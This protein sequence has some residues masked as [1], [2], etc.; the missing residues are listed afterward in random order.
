MFRCLCSF[1]LP[2]DQNPFLMIG[3]W[4]FILKFDSFFSWCVIDADFR[5]FLNLTF[6]IAL[7]NLCVIIFRFRG[8]R[9]FV[10]WH[11]C[12]KLGIRTGQNAGDGHQ[13]WDAGQESSYLDGRRHSSSHRTYILRVG[14]NGRL[15]QLMSTQ[16]QAIDGYLPHRDLPLIKI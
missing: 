8:G 16:S 10:G 12:E 13:W 11:I 14:R 6:H 4:R 3:C 9:S 1:E 5:F 15:H 2:W 7:M